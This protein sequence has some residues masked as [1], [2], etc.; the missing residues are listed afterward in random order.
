MKSLPLVISIDGT[1]G[2]GKSTVS[3]RIAEILGIPYLNTGIMYR[4]VA[5][6]KKMGK[7]NFTYLSVVDDGVMINGNVISKKDLVGEDVGNL[8][9]VIAQDPEIRKRLV[10]IQR[11]WALSKG[12]VIEGRDI[13]S[14]VIPETENKFFITALPKIRA[15]RRMFQLGKKYVSEED[16]SKT[17]KEI[18]IRD[19][20]DSNRTVSPLTIPKGAIVIDSSFLSI[21]EVV[22]L[23]L[24]EIVL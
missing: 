5:L 17:L 9:S 16:I 10:D 19:K 22:D 24:E 18:E 7:D 11:R 6:W 8:A 13:G 4:A 1:S 2:S 12:G 3:K 15:I 23:I 20:R 14:V 21:E